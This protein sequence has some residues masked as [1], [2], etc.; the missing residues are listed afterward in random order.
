MRFLTANYLYP[1]HTI[2]IKEGVLQISDNGKVVAIFEKRADVP[3][4]KLEIFNGI[5]CPGFVNSHCHLELS[6]LLGI[7]EKGK[8]FLNFVG[9]IQQRNNFT[10]DKILETIEK[11]ERQ[12]I[13]NGIVAVGDICNTV[14][15]LSQKQKGNL[16]YYNFIEIFGVQKE[17]INK[18][19]EDGKELRNQF[20]II[21]QK[22]TIVPHAP[23]SVPPNLMKAIAKT[24]DKNDFTLSIHNQEIKEE[25]EPIPKKYEIHGDLAEII[26]DMELDSS[27]AAVD[28]KDV[29]GMVIELNGKICFETLSAEMQP[30]LKKFL[31]AAADSFL[32]VPKDKHQIIVE[33]HSDND[34]IPKKYKKLYPSNWELSSARASVVVKYLIDKGVNPSRLVAH[35]Y[36]DRWPAD[37]TW[38]DMRRGYQLRPVGDNVEV[39]IGRGGQPEYSGIELDEND[40][41][42]FDKI[43]M[44]AVIDSLNATAELMEKNRRIKIIFTRQQFVDGIDKQF[45]DE[46][47]RS[48]LTK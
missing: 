43:S 20:R 39:I 38:A 32:T 27:E 8:G 19:I 26:E 15:T 1:L 18:V 16:Q 29:R 5:L 41:P 31:D 44:D 48:G 35:G 30:Q 45:V 21:G 47:G 34:P 2:P 17:K 7:T 33:G 11:A 36:A 13:K 25:N 40:V 22:A 4:E 24:F 9:G 37:M 42:I 10:K 12:M 46:P 28:I 3:K 6:H 23:Y 14:D